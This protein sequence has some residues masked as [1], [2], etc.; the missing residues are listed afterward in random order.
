VKEIVMLL[1]VIQA[2]LMTIAQVASDQHHSPSAHTPHFRIAGVI[3]HTY[4]P[5]GVGEKHLFIP[6]WGLDIEWWQNHHWGIGLHND[7]ELQ[8][9][10]VEHDG[11]E[12]VEREYPFV[13]S[14]DFL[15][16]PYKGWVLQLGPGVEL[17]RNRDYVLIRAG[18]E[19]EFEFHGEGRQRGTWDISPMLFYD[20]RLAAND[21]WSIGIGIGRRF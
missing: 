4:I 2:P 8:S 11:H 3:A 12:F 9:F 20:N 21:T 6:S 17:E 19:Y 18:L 14:L 1:I 5:T 10:I 13:M 7:L 15:Y 16:R